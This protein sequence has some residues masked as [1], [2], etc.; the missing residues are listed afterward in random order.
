MSFIGP[1]FTESSEVFRNYRLNVTFY[2]EKD[3]LIV[4]GYFAA[5]GDAANTSANSG[6]IWQV[7]FTP[8]KEGVWSYKVS[9]QYGKDLAASLDPNEGKPLAFDGETG[10]FE[11]NGINPNAKGAYAKGKLIYVGQRYLQYT[12]TGEW[13]IKAGPGG[14]ENFFG[15]VDFD[16]TFNVSGGINDSALG[17]DGLHKYSPHIQD[18]KEGDPVWKGDKGKAIVGS[19]NYLAEKGVNSLYLVVNN[20]NGDGRDCWP[21]AGYN[22]R[23]IYDVSKL[24]QWNIV[25]KHMNEKGIQLDFLFW[26]SENTTLLNNG[27]LGVERKIYYRELLARFGHL[28]AIRWNIS[29]EPTATPEQI[30]ADV[31]FISRIDPYGHAVGVHCGYT[32]ERRDNEYPPLLGKENF[33]GAFMQCHENLHDEVKRW[34]QKSEKSGKKWVVSVDE[35]LPNHPADIEKVR[36]EFWEVVTAG[37]EGY[38]VYF[39]YGTGTC[40]IANEDFRNRDKKWSQLAIGLDFFNNTELNQLLPYMKNYDDL[41]TGYILAKPG[42]M[43]VMYTTLDKNTI[44]LTDF[45]QEFEIDWLDINNESGLLKGSIEKVMGGQI[46]DLGN[47]PSTKTDWVVW[48]H[49]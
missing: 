22:D 4:P 32:V 42:E 24:A 7:V 11:V 1:N 34:L 48:I 15:Y 29:E 3:T 44:D 8:T 26:E 27:N 14:P 10:N 18:W 33:D 12:G 21:W 17:P 2:N 28:P 25:F 19:I 47:A 46:V 38:D 6:N 41:G 35:S 5:D 30:L 37:G 9:F 20:V 31:D 45:T 16:S 39:G 43:Y 36:R 49:Y 13:L 40:D 23:D